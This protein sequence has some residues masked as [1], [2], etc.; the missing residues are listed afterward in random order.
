MT[1]PSSTLSHTL[2]PTDTRNSTIIRNVLLAVF[3]VAI[4]TLS[5]KIKVP[6]YP[7]P[8][9]LQPM[10]VL[11][12][13]A[14]FGFRLGVATLLLYVAEGALGIPVFAGTPEKGV[15]IAYLMGPTGGYIFGFVLAA[16]AVGWLAERGWDRNILKMMIACLIGLALMYIPGL[17]QL[18]AI[19]G[20]DKPVLEW[21]FY[22]FILADLVKLAIVAIGFPA[23][24]SL[25]D[26]P[27]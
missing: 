14:A 1:S 19:V 24:W 18:G 23:V 12:I 21:G 22:P 16:G 6:M 10:V 3:G 17:L 7:V 4:L 8:V 2:W 11:G 9:T 13:G 5:A 20:F 25:F 27:M 26:R 15:G